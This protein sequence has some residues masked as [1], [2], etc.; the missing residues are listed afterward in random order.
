MGVAVGRWARVAEL[1]ARHTSSI[2]VAVEVVVTD[3]AP[4]SVDLRLQNASLLRRGLGYAVLA[5][6]PQTADDARELAR[7]GWWAVWSVLEPVVDSST[8][9]FSSGTSLVRY[10][11]RGG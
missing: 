5:H 2:Q 4:F 1:P 7:R 11:T 10:D 9:A 6:Q 8:E 3:V